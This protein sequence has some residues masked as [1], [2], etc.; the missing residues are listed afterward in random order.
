MNINTIFDDFFKLTLNSMFPYFYQIFK[1]KG[2][3]ILNIS[4]NKKTSRR[5]CL[6]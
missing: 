4:G 2:I 5:S 6:D 3:H 1:L